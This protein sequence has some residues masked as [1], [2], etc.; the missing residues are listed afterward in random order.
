[1]VR[2]DQNKFLAFFLFYTIVQL[3]DADTINAVMEG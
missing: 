2:I 3:Y 1:M